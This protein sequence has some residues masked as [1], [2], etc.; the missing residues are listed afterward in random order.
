MKKKESKIPDEDG[1]DNKVGGNMGILKFLK[2]SL[3]TNMDENLKTQTVDL[4]WKKYNKAKEHINEEL[5]NTEDYI[6]I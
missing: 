6:D 4:H 2:T 1:E 5:D 3:K